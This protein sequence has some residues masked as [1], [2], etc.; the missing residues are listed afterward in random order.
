MV[1]TLPRPAQSAM[2]EAAL[3]WR[4][5]IANNALPGIIITP[6]EGSTASSSTSTSTTSSS[7][8]SSS[9]ASS[10]SPACCP[11]PVGLLAHSVGGGLAPYVV[12]TAAKKQQPFTTAHVMAPQVGAAAA[13]HEGAAMA[14]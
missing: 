6:P 8:S 14:V 1:D 12:A 2:V 4:D 5:L 9:S 3:F 13:N 10:S 11:L 7:S